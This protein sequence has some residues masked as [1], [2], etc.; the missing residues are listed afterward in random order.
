MSKAALIGKAGEALVAAELMRRG[1]YVA[2]PAYDGGIDLIAYREENP[3]RIIPIQVK[4]RARSCYNFQ[5]AWLAKA[6]GIVLVQVWDIETDPKF[7]VF[8]SLVEI[9][10]ALGEHANSPSWRDKGGYNVTNPTS[11]HLDRMAPH[12][13]RWDRIISQL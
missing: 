7:Y 6:P 5:K 9:C 12:R 11:S 10:E 4:A 8:S 2:H 1:V 13:A 3:T